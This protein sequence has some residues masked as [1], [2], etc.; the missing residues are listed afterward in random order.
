MKTCYTFSIILLTLFVF[1]F[2]SCKR[3]VSLSNASKVSQLSENPFMFNLAKSMLKNTANYMLAQGLK[4]ATG[5]INL[6]T[7][8][9]SI[10][11]SPDKI[12]GFTDMLSNLYKILLFVTQ[13]LRDG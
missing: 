1:S 8:L 10:I 7:P 13:T 6:M 11:S 5:K 9:V 4:S 3:Y 2:T 12:G